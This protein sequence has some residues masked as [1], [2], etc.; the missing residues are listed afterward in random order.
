MMRID[1][2]KGNSMIFIGIT[3]GVGA[4]K[5]AVLSYLKELDGV[6]VMLSD[7]IAH[8]L[9]EPG[10]E[11]LRRVS[12][13]LGAG[14][15]KEEGSDCYNRLKELFAG[16]P[17]WLEDGHFDRPALAGVIFSNE[18]KRELLNEVVHPAVKE[19]VLNAVK[20][21][22][23]DGLFMLVLEAALLIEEGY[24]EICDE[25]W[26]IYA[27]EEV[28]RRRLKSSRGYSDEKIDSIFASQLKE[29]EYRRHC[30]EVID[31][32]GDIENTIASIN[33]AL[34]KYKE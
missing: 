12:E 3:G 10:T 22:K 34:S 7:E 13:A 14:F 19:Y 24:G 21:A 4:G 30:K 8:E 1:D 6:R 33:K 5:S 25:L 17:I 2:R 23:K 9:M 26:Y 32:D 31:N 18:K 29:D 16:E 11:G 20:E 28:R 15:L 27:S